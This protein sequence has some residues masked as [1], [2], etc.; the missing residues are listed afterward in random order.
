MADRRRFLPPAK[1]KP[2]R[3]ESAHPWIIPVIVVV[4]VVV[5]IGGIVWASALGHLF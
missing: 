1:T 2:E 5:V 4:A 3:R